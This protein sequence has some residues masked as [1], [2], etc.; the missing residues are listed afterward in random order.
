MNSETI[1]LSKTVTEEEGNKGSQRQWLGQVILLWQ[2]VRIP[3]LASR[4]SVGRHFAAEGSYT[5]EHCWD[6][7][8]EPPTLSE[9]AFKSWAAAVI[10]R[11]KPV[12]G[13][14][15]HRGE[16][17]SNNG[18]G[19]A[20]PYH[21][22]GASVFTSTDAGQMREPTHHFFHLTPTIGTLSLWSVNGDSTH[23]NHSQCS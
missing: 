18:R 17:P 2:W 8:T 19:G 7:Q 3:S 5:S 21:I 4:L 13:C 1:C 23:A 11:G 10:L 20:G 9:L 6:V 12:W 16:K 15:Q 14:G 22:T